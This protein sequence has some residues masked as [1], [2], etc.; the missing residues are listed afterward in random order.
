M[1]LTE[2]HGE[3]DEGKWIIRLQTTEKQECRNR[4]AAERSRMQYGDLAE[5]E[6]HQTDLSHSTAQ[7][8]TR[9]LRHSG[10][11][12]ECFLE[13][14][15]IQE[16]TY[17]TGRKEAESFWEISRK[18][19][20]GDDAFTETWERV[21]SVLVKGVRSLGANFPNLQFGD[22]YFQYCELILICKQQRVCLLFLGLCLPPDTCFLGVWETF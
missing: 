11:A 19:G 17:S 16:Q 1:V 20:W 2:K 5:M 6:R 4:A 8:A 22:G 21:Q 12:G 14:V 9:I 3:C 10:T 15:S 18:W 7:R 13:A